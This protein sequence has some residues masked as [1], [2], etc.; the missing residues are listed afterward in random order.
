MRFAETKRQKPFSFLTTKAKDKLDTIRQHPINQQKKQRGDCCHYKHSQSSSA[1]FT[2]RCPGNPID[3][4]TDL[5]NKLCGR[6]FSHRY[7]P[8]QVLINQYTGTNTLRFSRVFNQANGQHL[9]LKTVQKVRR[10][11]HSER[12]KQYVRDIDLLKRQLE[13]AE[14]DYADYLQEWNAETPPKLP[15]GSTVH[16]AGLCASPSGMNP[17]E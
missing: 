15:G 9:L 4:L 14:A 10:V 6:H 8:I 13:A 3:F 5:S 11:D 2:P 12:V 16:V 1:S 17:N 7:L